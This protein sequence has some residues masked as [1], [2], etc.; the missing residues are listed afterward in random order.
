MAKKNKIRK[1][2]II[3]S[4]IVGIL[5]ILGFAVNWFLTY[6]LEDILRDN[7]RQSIRKATDNFYDFTFSEL[8]VGLWDGELCIKG[9]AFFPDSLTMDS[10]NHARIQLPQNYFDVRVAEIDLKGLNLTWLFNRK[11]LHFKKFSLSSPDISITSSKQQKQYAL[12]DSSADS[13]KFVLPNLYEFIEPYFDYIKVDE[14][15]FSKASVKYQLKDS[16]PV[17]YQLN[18]FDFKAHL[19][20]L[21]EASYLN[22]KLLYSDYFNFKSNIPQDIFESEQFTFRINQIEVSTQDSIILIGG[23]HL[24]TNKN[25]WSQKINE[26]GERIDAQ[27]DKIEI[28]KMSLRWSD[29]G[30]VLSA[31]KFEVNKP[32]I[33]YLS[34]L[35]KAQSVLV[36]STPAEPTDSL[37]WSLYDILSPVFS[38][39]YI[40]TIQLGTANIKYQ[41][42]WRDQEYLDTYMLSNLNALARGFESDSSSV[43]K[44][45]LQYIQNLIFDTDSLRA[46]VPSKNSDLNVGEFYFDTQHKSISAANIGIGPVSTAQNKNYTIGYIEKVD[47][48]GFDYQTGIK[49]DTIQIT[50]PKVK[51]ILNKM[52]TAK[53]TPNVDKNEDVKNALLSISPFVNYIKIGN[54]GIVDGELELKDQIKKRDYSVSDFYF[55]A[56]NFQLNESAIIDSFLLT[57]DEYILG[58][59]NF[60]NITPDLKYRIKIKEALFNSLRGDMYISDFNVQPTE[61]NKDARISV[62]S[63]LAKLESIDLEALKDKRIIF[64]TFT[65]QSPTIEIISKSDNKKQPTKVAKKDDNNLNVLPF[66]QLSFRN[67]YIPSPKVS[68]IDEAA[69]KSTNVQTNLV[70]IDKLNWIIGKKFDVENLTIDKPTILINNN[71]RKVN[72]PKENESIISFNFEEINVKKLDINDIDIQISTPRKVIG[73]QA[74]NYMLRNMKLETLSRSALYLDT[75][76]LQKPTIVLKMNSYGENN[77]TIKPKKNKSLNLSSLIAQLPAL[78]NEAY[79]N[80]LDID[81]LNLLYENIDKEGELIKQK[82]N[83]TNFSLDNIKFNKNKHLL[84]INDIIFNTKKYQVALADSFYTLN[85]EN[86]YFGKAQKLFEI[87]SIS[88]VSN[89]PKFNFAYEQPKN[90]SWFNINIGKV[91]FEGLDLDTYIKKDIVYTDKFILKDVLLQNFK[92]QKIETPKRLSPLL[93]QIFQKVPIKYY[94][95]SVDVSNFSVIYDELDKKNFRPGLIAF[96]E[97]NGK[98][99]GFTNIPDSTRLFYDLYA[100]G[101]A[102]G[103]GYFDAVWTMPI[104][105]ATNQFYLTANLQPMSV[106]ALNPLLRPMAPIDVRGIVDS[107]YFDASSTDSVA[108]VKLKFL[109]HDIYVDV[110]KGQRSNEVNEI[111]TQL[112]NKLVLRHS[113]PMKDKLIVANDSI[114]RNPYHSNFNYIWQMLRPPLVQSVGVGKGKQNFAAQIQKFIFKMK[115]IFDHRRPEEKEGDD[116]EVSL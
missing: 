78:T 22:N 38:G 103:E 8:S 45:K 29:S 15:D 95:D 47:V 20:A 5:L 72:M 74:D 89:V 52:S 13:V 93:Y 63:S 39:V 35:N 32:T 19:F 80:I 115:H 56:K 116:K 92:D 108:D 68:I 62:S 12:Q 26:L 48:V 36:D 79:I 114:V 109:Y 81:N 11:K 23:A 31:Q 97:M 18:G 101:K 49:A 67:L 65:L 91:A 105:T 88:L 59:R 113:N 51:F 76:L 112:V 70:H 41:E 111:T 102:F 87:D 84:F 66:S 73:V 86:L 69:D 107:V 61:Y 27:V 4:V 94:V 44:S 98:I 37:N 1:I 40:D 34:V 28:N 75:M 58:F 55:S 85:I 110:F 90:A 10:L 17:L 99:K 46:Y 71:S 60:D 7:I 96:T 25:Y 2:G 57:W 14:I 82:L 42:Y 104:D 53:K 16:I 64:E 100:N 50:H 21:D 83:D 33:D 9:V 30:N 24:K 77:E 106:A 3:L 6:R 43:K 54:I